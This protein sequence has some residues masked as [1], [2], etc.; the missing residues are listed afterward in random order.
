MRRALVVIDMQ[1]DFVDGALGTREAQAIVP[2]VVN[3]IGEGG[4]DEVLATQDTHYDDYPDTLEGRK[5]PVPHCKAGTY[6]WLLNK[7]VTRALD[8]CDRAYC[9]FEKNTFGSIELAEHI[10]DGKFDEVVFCGLCTDICL[11]SNVL[12]A[13]AYCPDM[14]IKVKADC[15]AGVTP[16]T[17]EAALTTMRMC[18]VDII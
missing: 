3:L 6:G 17:H 15:C 9:A 4:F 16:E 10:R 1:N 7:D 5:L 11:V 8:N 14:T 12:M 13:R 18:Q 2:N